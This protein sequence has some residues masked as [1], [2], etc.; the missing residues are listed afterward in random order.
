VWLCGEGIPK[1]KEHVD[2]LFDDHRTDLL[3]ATK[4]PRCALYYRQ[5]NL[6]FKQSTRCAGA[7]EYMSRELIAMQC[8]PGTHLRLLAVMGYKREPLTLR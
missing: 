1:E 6:T 4:R 5:R 2:P 7:I 3:I 8:C